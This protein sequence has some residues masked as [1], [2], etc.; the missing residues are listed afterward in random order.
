M[1]KNIDINIG[2][3]LADLRKRQKMT[4][5]ELSTKSG[6]SKSIL[7]QIE[8]NISN[9]TV[10]TM[11]RIAEALNE[12]LSDFFTNINSKVLQ[13]KETSKEVPTIISKDG[14]CSLTI[15]GTGETVNW[16]Q[17]YILSMKPLGKLS[18]KSHG[19]N[20]Y[21]NITVINGEVEVELKKQSIILNVGDT[22]RY[23]TNQA[24]SVINKSKGISKVIMINYI[25]PMNGSFN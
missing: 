20:T 17:W 8:R 14:L 16:L 2:A 6:V 11:T 9:P 13:T 23:E 22:L 15:L 10:T 3:S 24:H 18:S 21:E 12:S 1:K 25:D 5:E 4:L 7:S 19:L